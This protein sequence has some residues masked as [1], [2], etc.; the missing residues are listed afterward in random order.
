ML[1]RAVAVDM[2]FADIEENPH[3]RIER[4]RQIDLVRRH[5]DHM[6][7]PHAR[8]LQRQD[9]GADIAAHL[10]V[11]AG[12]LHQMRNQR[13]CGRLAVGAGDGNER[14]VRRV[15]AALTAKQFDVADHLTAGLPRHQHRPMRRRMG[16]RRAGR[17][18]Q[19]R[20]IRPR[21]RAQIGGGETGLR[22]FG[23]IVGRVVARDHFR[24][25]GLQR[26]AARKAGTAEAEDGDRLAR[27]GGDGDH[28]ARLTAA[29]TWRGRPAP[30]SP[31]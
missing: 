6:H 11:V 2:V 25:T 7:P 18:N 3:R 14:R 22:R 13:C 1:Q 27:K 10:A 24:A 30:A 8:R 15:T 29:S 28:R 31:R 5:L 4:R 19:R 21:H 26:V 16:E 17:Q 9:R 23:D 12:D 20:K